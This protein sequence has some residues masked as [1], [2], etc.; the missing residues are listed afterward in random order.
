MSGDAQ[1][2]LKIE[3]TGGNPEI[4]FTRT[5]KDDSSVLRH[6][7]IGQQN[8]NNFFISAIGSDWSGYQFTINKLGDTSLANGQ[9]QIIGAKSQGQPYGGYLGSSNL[10]FEHTETDYLIGSHSSDK[11]ASVLQARVDGKISLN[12]YKP[13]G[14]AYSAS[15]SSDTPDYVEGTVYPAGSVVKVLVAGDF[16]VESRCSFEALVETSNKPPHADWREATP[17]TSIHIDPSFG[18][19]AF[20]SMHTTHKAFNKLNKAGAI[21][22]KL[23][24]VLI[25]I[26][27]TDSSNSLYIGNT[28]SRNELALDNNVSGGGAIGIQNSNYNGTAR[29]PLELNPM[30]GL[31]S[32][33][34]KFFCIHK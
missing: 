1:V 16:R 6:W 31:V 23:L 29:Y 10:R 26:I 30:G 17:T 33:G 12:H 4:Q 24:F 18:H 20:Y 15:S 8:S 13:G 5:D 7:A 22:D 32:V 2:K 19:T 28:D 3:S 25:P 21:S 34:G 9:M 14:I 11:F 27:H